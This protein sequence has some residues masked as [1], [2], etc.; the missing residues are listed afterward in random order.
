MTA[1]YC[2]GIRS[3]LAEPEDSSEASQLA[4]ASAQ[5]HVAGCVDCRAY[6]AQ[7]VSF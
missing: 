3:F 6:Y 4:R 5:A 7:T 1:Q 2:Q